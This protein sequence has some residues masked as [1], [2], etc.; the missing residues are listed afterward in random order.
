MQ[1]GKVRNADVARET[2][3]AVEGEP[4]W[5]VIN[6][7]K[8]DKWEQHKHWFNDIYLPACE[9][10]EPTLVRHSRILWPTGPNEDGT[11]TSVYIMDPYLEGEDYFMMSQLTKTFG[12]EKAKEYM[13]LYAESLVSPQVGYMVIQS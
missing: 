5:V 6:H 4:V 1:K 3:R 12:E 10:V 9:K 8:A 11:Y 13:Q 2:I 7:V